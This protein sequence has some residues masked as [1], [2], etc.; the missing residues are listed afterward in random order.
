MIPAPIA[1]AYIIDNPRIYSR[2]KKG[3]LG[4]MA[5]SLITL[6]A[7]AGV[8]G[9]VLSNNLDRNGPSPAIDWTES[10]FTAGF[11][12]YIL[13]GVIFACFQISVQ[14]T[15]ASMTND[16]ALC[17][18][19]AGAFK[20]TV[21]LGM[22]ISFTVDS[23]GVSFETQA[24]YQLV[25]Y[26]FGIA[27]LLYVIARYVKQTNYFLEDSVIVPLSMEEKAL[28]DKSVGA[29]ELEQQRNKIAATETV[30]EETPER[31]EVK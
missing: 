5:M 23:Q 2:R 18:R 24:I 25:T 8:L 29:E 7:I 4:A 6:G 31:G 15:L 17:A 20:G 16:P 28:Q 10:A 21:S 9:W 30:V 12:L 14:W 27:C 11:I 19:Y 1:L 13:A 26:A 3:L 22:C